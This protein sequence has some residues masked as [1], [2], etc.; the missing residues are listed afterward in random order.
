MKKRIL[1]A[2]IASM[3]IL[4]ACSAPADDT[5]GSTDT[6]NNSSTSTDTG[7][8][9]SDEFEVT[10]PIQGSDG[11]TMSYWIPLNSGAAK[12]ITN[13]SEALVWQETVVRTGIELE[14]IHPTIGD[15]ANQFNL[16]IVGGELPDIMQQNAYYAGGA[17]AS[18]NDGVAIDMT[19]YIQTYAPDY[20]GWMEK[21]VDLYKQLT[22]ADGQFSAFGSIKYS[23]PPWTRIS[24]RPDVMEDLGIDK[25]P[26]TIADYEAAFDLMLEAGMTP[27]ILPTTG[28][29]LMFSR[30][31]DADDGFH[32]DASGNVVYGQ[33]QEGFKEYVT[34]M[35]EWYEKGYISTDFVSLSSDDRNA[36]FDTKQLGVYQSAIGY[37]YSRAVMGDY[38]VTPLPYP[39]L[40]E[41]Q[42]IDFLEGSVSKGEG[43]WTSVSTQCE[44]PEIAIQFLNYAYSDEGADLYN[45]GVEGLTY[46]VLE[47][48]EYEFTDYMLFNEEID[49][50]GAIYMFKMHTMPKYAETDTK[51]N[52]NIV[53]DPKSVEYREMYSDDTSITDKMVLPPLQLSQEAN[54]E[55]AKILTEVSTYVNEMILKFIT[56]A[57]PLDE[58]D[59]YVAQVEAMDVARAVELTQ[60]AYDNY[61][62]KTLP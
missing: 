2:C 48:G 44:E 33:I 55:R 56:G 52:P 58:W 50:N 62:S 38:D 5:N 27:Y 3:V 29:D 32:L 31:F 21:D 59:S 39:R 49:R 12:Y 35:N 34:L 46:N 17:E 36:M 26:E 57:T 43:L 4:S 6:N 23:L 22:N 11:I 15:E 30:P 61:S 8:T 16:L 37:T 13:Y 25:I 47:N 9:G 18:V 60:E 19:P 40:E 51:A 28:Y 1:A 7:D 41:G 14:F 10:Y 20:Y 24:I 53:F 54:D 42:A 45:Y